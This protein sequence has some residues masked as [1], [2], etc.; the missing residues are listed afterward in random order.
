VKD[1]LKN[2]SATAPVPPGA[3]GVRALGQSGFLLANSRGKT[4]AIDPCLADPV[5]FRRELARFAPETECAV[6]KPGQMRLF[7]A[8][9]ER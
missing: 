6:L 7:G 8:K 9:D 5:A 2:P 4:V 3:L 1:L